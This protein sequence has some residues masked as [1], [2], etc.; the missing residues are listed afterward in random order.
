MS[1]SI[2][3]DTES[4]LCGNKKCLD[5]TILCFYF[6]RACVHNLDQKYSDHQL[7]K[8]KS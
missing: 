6:C 8:S 2:I 5:L 1:I 4:A 3:M 7:I